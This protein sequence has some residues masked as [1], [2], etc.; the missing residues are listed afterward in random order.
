[1]GD[2]GLGSWPM[3]RAR[4]SPD[5][6]A[7]QQADRSYSYRELATRVDALAAGLAARGVRHGDR[8]AYLGPNDIAAFE[9]FFAAGRLGSVFVPL[10][11]RL[12][13]P[14]ISYLLGDSAASVLVYRPEVSGLVAEALSAGLSLE[15]LVAVDRAD[16]PGGLD[17]ESLIA[18]PVREL[19]GAQRSGRG[20]SVG[21]D[22]DAL[23]LYTSGTTGQPKGAVLTHGNITFNTMNQLAH[24]DVRSSDRVLCS[25]P[26]F[27]VVGL[28]QVTLP[29]LFKGGTIVVAPK[30]DA[31]T[32]LEMVPKLGITAFAAVPTMLQM[33]CDAPSFA[34][35]DLGS[36]RYI[37]YGG[38]SV[39][40]R[41]ADAWIGRGIDVVQGYGMTEAAPGVL[42]AVPEGVAD[43][44]VSP[45]VPHFF[46][47]VALLTADGSIIPPPGTGE[48][49][50]RGPNVFRG[51]R[52][53]PDDTAQAFADGWFR[54]GDVVR[55][56]P[57]GWGYVVD[58]VKDMIIS[59]GENI[60][61][62]E[63]EAA[64]ADLPGVLDCAVVGVPDSVWGEVG[65]A[66][67]VGRPDITITV[68][69][70]HDHLAG[71][72]ARFKVPKYVRQ[73][74]DLP[75]NATGKVLKTRLREMAL[76]WTEHA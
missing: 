38:S 32:V 50:V 43:H 73:V 25:A 69:D 22:D 5:A 30:F 17:Y 34:E 12:T 49:L 56:D 9:T 35:E 6:P 4:I 74:T 58:R 51:Y 1:M 37:V 8:I 27:H 60:Y 21:L 63:V 7:M 41:V 36:L 62:A 26:I 2:L 23:I 16:G 72:L 54:S 3:R 28:G 65:F 68:A 64:I 76:G 48:L 46:T 18:E 59:G 70:V 13:A 11:T 29:T 55:L 19:D 67:V 61:P 15:L 24:T 66:L 40:A 42:L 53:R 57:D 71:R 39:L 20:A 10:N 33:M 45:G 44:Q 31:A 75:R 47:D 14:E 52:N